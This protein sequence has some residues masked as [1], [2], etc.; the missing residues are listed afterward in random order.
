MMNQNWTKWFKEDEWKEVK[1]CVCAYVALITCYGQN[2]SKWFKED[3]WGGETFCVCLDS[4]NNLLWSFTIVFTNYRC[5][6]HY[7]W[8]KR[9]ENH[10]EWI[11][12]GQN[13]SR[14]LNEEVKLFVCA[15]I[16]LITFDGHWQY[17]L[18]T[19]GVPTII[20]ERKG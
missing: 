14:K 12:I 13:G 19:I 15:W 5:P 9:L 6:Y 17:F 2:W 11:K 7:F 18:P 20:F 4:V 10:F 3:E 8:K 16:V 1:F